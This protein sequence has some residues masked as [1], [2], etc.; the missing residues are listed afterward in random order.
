MFIKLTMHDLNFVREAMGLF[1]EASGLTIN[2]RKMVAVLIQGSEE[3]R[4]RVV[5]ILHC[6]MGSFPCRYL[7]IQLAIKAVRAFLA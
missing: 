4:Q 1:G 6:E 3:D 2:Y 5:D 7:G